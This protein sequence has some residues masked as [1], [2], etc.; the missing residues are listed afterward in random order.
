MK[1]AK[2]LMVSI[3]ALMLCFSVGLT[4]PKKSGAWLG[5]YTQTVDH[6]VAEAFDLAVDYGAIVNKV[7]D[8]SPADE[9]GIR[10]DDVIVAFDGT[11]VID[12]G[13]LTDLVRYCRPGHEVVVTFMRNGNKKEI[14]VKLEKRLSSE[15]EV[16][17]S[18]RDS[19]GERCYSYS[20]SAGTGSYI[21]VSLIKLSEQLG[22]YFGVHDDEGVL[23]TE[24]AEDSPAMEAGLKAGDVILDVDSK[25]VRDAADVQKIIRRKDKGD[26]VDIGILRSKKKMEIAVEVGERE[27]LSP[28]LLVEP[29]LARL[30][31]NL[32]KMK[33][34][35]MGK[36]FDLDHYFDAEEFE[37][38]ME[39]LR[40]EL[41]E[42]KRELRH[43]KKSLD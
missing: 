32:P 39:Q 4:K 13:E 23:I 33:G 20:F 9:A 11:K 36:D 29:D 30:N 15:Q 31:L 2:L 27:D 17:I 8:E 40:E 5:V 34:L 16:R 42:L 35:Y 14:T 28:W 21:G 12:T 41:M 22:E 37:E 6:D 38:E 18:R 1:S 24:V 10:E 26:R 19:P 43:L 3:L 25:K 7:V